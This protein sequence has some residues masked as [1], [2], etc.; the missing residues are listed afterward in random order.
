[1]DV[2]KLATGEGDWGKLAADTFKASSYFLGIP[3]ASQLTITGDYLYDLYTQE[4]QPDSMWE[5][6]HNT[7]YRREKD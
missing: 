7:V 6:M 4:E 2:G 1:M 5:L 3:G